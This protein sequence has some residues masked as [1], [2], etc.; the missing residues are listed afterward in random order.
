MNQWVKNDQN[1]VQIGLKTT[2]T[3]KIHCYL[4]K[5]TH[6]SMQVLFFNWLELGTKYRSYENILALMIEGFI[7]Q[8]IYHLSV[9][10]KLSYSQGCIEK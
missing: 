4:I 7:Y 10:I 1:D 5:K 3:N 8:H 9:G 6:S 2:R